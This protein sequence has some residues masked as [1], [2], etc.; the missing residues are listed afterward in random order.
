MTQYRNADRR[1]DYTPL[2]PLGR[3]V[4]HWTVRYQ[5]PLTALVVFAVSALLVSL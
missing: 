1:L 2:Q 5:T 4:L 3:P